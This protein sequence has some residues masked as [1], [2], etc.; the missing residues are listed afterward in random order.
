MGRYSKARGHHCWWLQIDGVC[1]A[2]FDINAMVTDTMAE[3]MVDDIIALEQSV[4]LFRDTKK[5]LYM[6]DMFDNVS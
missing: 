2:N 6:H 1:V 5:T 3:K 4:I